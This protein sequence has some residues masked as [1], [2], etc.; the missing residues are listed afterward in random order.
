MSRLTYTGALSADSF[1]IG[2]GPNRVELTGLSG[3]LVKTS[4]T[5]I[6]QM[7]ADTSHTGSV[8]A[9]TSILIGSG[10]NRIELTSVASA[11]VV[12]ASSQ[13]KQAESPHT[14]SFSVENELIIGFGSNTCIL[15]ASGGN[16]LVNGV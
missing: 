12:T 3:A 8:R 11:L 7:Q 14:G 5:A 6:P 1:V 10:A 15:T 9:L 4:R 16:L 2:E 13:T